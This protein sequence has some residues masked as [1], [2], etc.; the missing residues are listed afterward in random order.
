MLLEDIEAY[1]IYM[2][3]KI[4]RKVP[5]DIAEVGVYKGGSAKIICSAK[6]D[7]AL[8]LFDTF[9]ACQKLTTLIRSGRFTRENLLRPMIT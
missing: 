6:G 8:Y 1:H 5:G 4:T 9:P 2:A 7:R 3:S